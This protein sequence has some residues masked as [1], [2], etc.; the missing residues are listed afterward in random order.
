MMADL[1]IK[2][3]GGKPFSWGSASIH[4]TGTLRTTYI[5]ALKAA[6][7]HDFAPLL[8]FARVRPGTI[9]AAGITPSKSQT[10]EPISA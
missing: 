5:N 10:N 1:L 8:A 2:K 3:L 6:D 9:P 4:D 7:N